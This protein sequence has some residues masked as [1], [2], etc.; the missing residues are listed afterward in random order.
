MVPKGKIICN[1]STEGAGWLSITW[2]KHDTPKR[3]HNSGKRRRNSQDLNL[4]CF[5]TSGKQQVEKEMPRTAGQAVPRNQYI[6]LV[7]RLDKDEKR[8]QFFTFTA[9]ERKGCLF[10]SVMQK[11]VRMKNHYTPPFRKNAS[12]TTVL[13]KN[14]KKMRKESKAHCRAIRLKANR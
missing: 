13:L 1:N 10:L 7:F 3:K 2:I 14:Q 8:G 11:N 4:Y 5:C 9:D 12:K 6:D